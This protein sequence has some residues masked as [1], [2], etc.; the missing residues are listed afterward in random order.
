MLCRF[1]GGGSVVDAMLVVV[2]LI[3]FNFVSSLRDD[4]YIISSLRWMKQ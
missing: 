2:L 4:G 1:S 3:S